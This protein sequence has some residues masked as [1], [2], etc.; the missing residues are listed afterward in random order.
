MGAAPF[1]A[2]ADERS[3]GAGEQ[4]QSEEPVHNV[5]S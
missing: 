4:E 3:G 1:L 5:T 2:L